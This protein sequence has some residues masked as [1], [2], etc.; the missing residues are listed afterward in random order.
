MSVILNIL[1][2]LLI[3]CGRIE[4]HEIQKIKDIKSIVGILDP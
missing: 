1:H 3:S 2:N 4:I